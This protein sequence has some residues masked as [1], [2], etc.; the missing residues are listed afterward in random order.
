MQTRIR[1][2][3]R[4]KLL[5]LF[6]SVILLFIVSTMINTFVTR[7]MR[8]SMS[9]LT[10]IEQRLLLIETL[11]FDV[12]SADDD[13]AWAMLSPDS[14][15][16][17]MYLG[18]WG[19]DELTVTAD[20]GK[21]EKLSLSK[22]DRRALAAFRAEWNSYISQKNEAD[23]ALENNHLDVAR[24]QFLQV[25]FEP[26]LLSLAPLTKA[27]Q[28]AAQNQQNVV[29]AE[30]VR[31]TMVSWTASGVAALLGII[32]AFFYASRITKTIRRVRDAAVSIA[33]GHLHIDKLELTSNDELAELTTAINEMIDSLHQIVQRVTQHSTEVAVAAEQLTHS[34]AQST[35]AAQQISGLMDEMAAGVSQQAQRVTD[36]SAMIQGMTA[37]VQRIAL[38]A[39]DVSASAFNADR[40][41]Q[42]GTGAVS[43]STD[44]MATI[45]SS[46]Q[47]LSTIIERM[48]QRS[49]EI[50]KIV[51]AISEITKQT[52]LLALNAA[53]EAAR[54][55]EHGLG[56]AVVAQEVRRLAEESARSAR[57]IEDV[58]TSVQADTED[59]TQQMSENAHAVEE[60]MHAIVQASSSFQRIQEAVRTV[61]EQASDVTAELE[62]ISSGTRE[63]ES[64]IQFIAR[65]AKTS[66]SST[67]TVSATTQEQSAT[68]LTI[69]KAA[70][71]LAASSQQLKNAISH[72]TV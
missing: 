53:I 30:M 52:N 72:F 15:G 12:R 3:L 44:R 17:S 16:Q 55:G 40:V 23:I 14:M 32:I 21:L 13:G 62:D 25:P 43:T 22:A 8:Q 37:G 7:S 48:N 51:N 29:D 31:A 64:I 35:E 41:A 63:V 47:A 61:V 4:T 34:V 56:F 45:A 10:N 70:S 2:R 19:A 46:V 11:N 1:I 39:N 24:R 36:G 20:L 68:L 49:E 66:A 71:D 58:I 27:L 38:A 65:L 67:E 5:L 28:V 60:G 54:A 42:V 33:T 6:L 9:L 26:V 50:G 59:A 69:L 57:Q 18:S